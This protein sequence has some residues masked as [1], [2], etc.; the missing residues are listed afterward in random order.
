LGQAQNIEATVELFVKHD[1][2]LIDKQQS[3]YT[4]P[5]ALLETTKNARAELESILEGDAKVVKSS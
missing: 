2:D 1:L 3:V 5:K 4:D